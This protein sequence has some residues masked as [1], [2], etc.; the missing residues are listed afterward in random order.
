MK[1]D[2]KNDVRVAAA[3]G[4]SYAAR[5]FEPEEIA[6]DAVRLDRLG[7]RAV[8]AVIRQLPAD[9]TASEAQEIARRYNAEVVDERDPNG[10]ILGLRFLDGS[11]ADMDR[12]IFRV[13]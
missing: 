2:R 9:K 4:K 11:Y 13:T 12:H 7:K 10:I 3:L 8:D 1:V 6:A 5:R